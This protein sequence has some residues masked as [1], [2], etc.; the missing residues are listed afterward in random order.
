MN[1]IRTVIIDDEPSVAGVHH[2]FLMAHGAFEVVGIA[3]TGAQGLELVSALR[4]ELLLLDIHLPDIGGLEVLA[5]LRARLEGR[6]LDVF[7]IT[8]A[9]ELSTVRGALAGGVIEYLVKPF[10]S[11]EFKA[12]LDHYVAHRATILGHHA[13]EEGLDQHSIDL[14]RAGLPQPTEQGPSTAPDASRA[15]AAVP[16]RVAEPPKGLSRATLEAVMVQLRNSNRDYSASEFAAE[17]GLAR[18]SARRYLE[19]LVADGLARCTPRYGNAGRPE[20][21]YTLDPAS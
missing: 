8:A 20:N 15:G 17:L 6:L 11:A 13:T 5:A 2:G 18:V 21:R 10:G 14:L 12:R 19:F 3:H 9:R 4:P 16:T 7:A 1:P